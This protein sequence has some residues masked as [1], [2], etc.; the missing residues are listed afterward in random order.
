MSRLFGHLSRFPDFHALSENMGIDHEMT[1]WSDAV[2]VKRADSSP[3]L[4]VHR[5]ADLPLPFSRGRPSIMH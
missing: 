1:E 4:N 2:H 5:K 3:V